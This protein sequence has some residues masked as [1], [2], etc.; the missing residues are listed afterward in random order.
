MEDGDGRLI[1]TDEQS[2]DA[3]VV[4]RDGSTVRVRPVRADDEQRVDVLFRLV[5]LGPAAVHGA[6]AQGDDFDLGDLHGAAPAGCK[7]EQ[8]GPV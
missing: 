5:P 1:S 7:G 4:L 8:K 3:D 2:Y 6:A